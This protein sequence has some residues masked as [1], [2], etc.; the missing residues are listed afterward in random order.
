MHPTVVECLTGEQMCYRGIQVRGESASG[1]LGFGKLWVVAEIAEARMLGEAF[2]PDDPDYNPQ[3]TAM[4]K[5]YC[6][7]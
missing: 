3:D 2:T 5:I 7:V 6:G 4:T 1:G